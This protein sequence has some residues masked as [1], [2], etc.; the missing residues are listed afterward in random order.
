MIKK[1]AER[2]SDKFEINA[3]HDEIESF[4][5]EYFDEN[6]TV[7]GTNECLEAVNSELEKYY[8]KQEAKE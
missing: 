4:I 1:L 7:Y 3:T 2:L 6:T 5:M 8:L